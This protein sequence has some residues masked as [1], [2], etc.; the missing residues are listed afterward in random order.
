MTRAAR[1]IGQKRREEPG[2]LG[3]DVLAELGAA[4]EVAAVENGSGIVVG[5]GLALPGDQPRFAVSCA[6]SCGHSEIS[7]SGIL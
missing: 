5:E 2:S 4:G 7:P 3:S 6:S 1:G